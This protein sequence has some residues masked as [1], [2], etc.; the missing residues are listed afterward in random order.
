MAGIGSL[1]ELTAAI[2]IHRAG[3]DML[4]KANFS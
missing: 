3:M 1:I 4:A 2:N